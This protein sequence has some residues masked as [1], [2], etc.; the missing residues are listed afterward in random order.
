M[1]SCLFF[2]L[3]ENN[4]ESFTNLETFA[5]YIYF[6]YI[7]S[8]SNPFLKSDYLYFSKPFLQ[9]FYKIEHEKTLLLAKEYAIKYPLVGAILFQELDLLTLRFDNYIPGEY[10]EEFKWWENF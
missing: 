1:I 3:I 8:F 5:F 9:S 6:F 4:L 2:N 10:I 7:K